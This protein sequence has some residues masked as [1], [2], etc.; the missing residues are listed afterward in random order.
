MGANLG[1]RRATMQ[2]GLDALAATD[3]LALVAVSSV[4][5]T[6]P[7]GGPDGQPA[8]LNAV[9]V[10][11]SRLGAAGL[12]ALL[13]EVEAA[14]GRVREVRWGPRTLDL[15]LLAYGSETS[16]D[17]R[18]TLPHPRAHLRAFVLVPWAEVD[19]VYEVPGLDTSVA[20]LAASLDPGD[21]A[22]VRLRA[23]IPLV[24]P[25]SPVDG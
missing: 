11:D 13:Q 8:F 10:G 9:L 12:L 19:P 5:E 18:L 2:S 15:D 4:Y 25:V 7:V 6:D 24:V 16:D 20:R 22:G 21:L 23:D 14:H 17:P 3:G 1:D